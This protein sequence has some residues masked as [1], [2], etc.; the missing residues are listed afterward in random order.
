[1]P[2]IK[3]FAVIMAVLLAG[4]AYAQSPA[5]GHI[6]G[7]SYVNTYF[8]ISYRW[9]A[10]L[11]P[12][13]LPTPSAGLNNP[14]TYA[15]PLF[16]ARQGDQRYGVVI[17]A[18]KLNVAGPHSAGVKSSADFIDR[19]AHSLRPGPILSNISRSQKKNAHGIVFEKLGYLQSGK[20]AS[21]MAIQDGQYLIVFKCNAQSAADIARMEN[22]VLA[23]R[24][25]K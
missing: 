20:P 5:D 21:V 1:M 16:S 7:T 9:P 24:M 14:R 17:E 6:A 22:S 4:A 23:L 18:E 3:T 11:R 2:R 15:F 13:K 19:I 12:V 25:L 10:M 8:H